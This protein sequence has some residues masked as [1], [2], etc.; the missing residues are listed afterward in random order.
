MH[1]L[2]SHIHH[3]ASPA[4]T[5]KIF[6]WIYHESISLYPFSCALYILV[7]HCIR[8]F[9]DTLNFSFLRCQALG[10]T[11][12]YQD[13]KSESA[14]VAT[15]KCFHISLFS[16]ADQGKYN[17]T[18]SVCHCHIHSR[19]HFPSLPFCFFLIFHSCFIVVSVFLLLLFQLFAFYQ[20]S[21]VCGNLFKPLYCISKMN[22]FSQLCCLT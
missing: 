7:F 11:L 3:N 8:H 14:P 4:N 19:R 5:L 1:F 16:Q 15:L 22:V 20:L 10:A 6:R 2:L 21:C 17:F 12:T 9:L 18:R 13:I